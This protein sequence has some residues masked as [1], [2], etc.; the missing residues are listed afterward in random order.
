[1]HQ[2]PWQTTEQTGYGPPTPAGPPGVLIWYKIFC[3]FNALMYLVILLLGVAMFLAPGLAEELGDEGAELYVTGGLF[4]AM[5]ALLAVPYA[6]P[7]FLPP[8]KGAWILGIVLIAVSMTSCCFL[9]VAIVLLIYWINE[10]TRGYF[11]AGGTTS[12]TS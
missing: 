6:L 2:D 8:T 1:M 12:G 10:N 5:G 9:P 3:A 7:L 11:E 4:V